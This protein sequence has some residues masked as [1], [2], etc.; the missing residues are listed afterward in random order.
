MWG[1]FFKC[2][3]DVLREFRFARAENRTLDL[4]PFGPKFSCVKNLLLI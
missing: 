3:R 2:F 1:I 4:K